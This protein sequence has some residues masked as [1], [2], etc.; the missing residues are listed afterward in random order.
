MLQHAKLAVDSRVEAF[1]GKSPRLLDQLRGCARAK[2]YSLRTEEAYV[3]WVR[4]F[5]FF[6]KKR[7]PQDMGASEIQTFLTHLAV[8]RHV[9]PSTQNQAKSAL[10]FLYREVLQVELPWLNEIVQAKHSPRLPV[11]LTP[12]EVR[13]LLDQMEGVMLLV[14]RLL[15]G[16]GVRLMEALSLRVKDVDFEKR[17]IVV[18]CGKGGKDRVTMLP[19]SLVMPL[20]AHLGRVKQLH[21]KDLAEGYG[22]VFLPDA[23]AEKSRAASRAWGW[24]WVFPSTVRSTDPR[25]GVVRRHHVHPESVQKA[26]RT[27]ARSAELVK[28]VSPH[29]LRHSFATHLLQNGYDIRTAQEL[30]GHRDVETTM[31][32]THV[33]NRGGLAVMSPLDRM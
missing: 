25:G 32:Y 31:I 24:Q 21:E 18:R 2:H 28:P 26:V 33:L 29:V 16:T 5:V 8:E 10:L 4:R 13:A 3:D 19:D 22:E 1:E 27:A 17:E 20:K 15:Y 6:H 12:S 30:L 11:V 14:T 23:L 7:H 9:S